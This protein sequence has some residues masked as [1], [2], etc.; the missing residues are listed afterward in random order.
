MHIH[1]RVKYFLFCD[2][3]KSDER[4][5]TQPHMHT[6][7]AHIDDYNHIEGPRWHKSRPNTEVLA[8]TDCTTSHD[9][10]SKIL[11]NKF[12]ILAKPVFAGTS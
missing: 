3:Y 7:H 8:C 2:D 1:A 9:E 10:H 4:T 12:L 5:H 11:P 6:T